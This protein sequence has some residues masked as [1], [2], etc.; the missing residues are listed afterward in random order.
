MD[1][2]RAKGYAQAHKTF[3]TEN[4]PAVLKGMPEPEKYLAQVGVTA[5]QMFDQM[6]DQMQSAINQRF[7]SQPE[8]MAEKMQELQAIPLTVDEIVMSE[9]IRQP[10]PQQ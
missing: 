1:Q 6:A 3:L 2:Q 7:A 10:L 9:V 5:A 8:A 4:N